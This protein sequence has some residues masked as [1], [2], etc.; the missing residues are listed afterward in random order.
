MPVPISEPFGHGRCSRI[1]EE[2]GIKV[3][4]LRRLQAVIDEHPRKVHHLEAIDDIAA[5]RVLRVDVDVLVL[6]LVD[7]DAERHRPVE[8]ERLAERDLIVLR[9]APLLGLDRERLAAAEEVRRL[10]R[11]LT[12][13]AFELRHAGAKRQLIAVLLLER[14]LEV[15]L[16]V[17]S[18]C[19]LDADCIPFQRFEVTELIETPD[20]VLQ[21][22]SVE[23]ARFEQPDLTP[24]DVIARRRIANERNAIDEVL[25]AFLE[26]HRHV[27]DR[28]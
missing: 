5:D 9:A 21:R 25:L 18:R 19:L 6:A 16:V 7:V 20:G 14:Q 2:D 27:D 12:E 11:Q 17:C 4:D 3:F 1:A 24:N 28:G 10:E 15:D 8:Q 23:H 26:A 13:E 22:L